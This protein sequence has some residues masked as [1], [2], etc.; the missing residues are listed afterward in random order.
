MRLIRFLLLALMFLGAPALMNQAAKAAPVAAASLA[1]Q[2]AAPDLTEK[3]R[4][5]CYN[6]YSGRFLHW[7][8]CGYRRHYY[9]HRYYWRPHYYHRHYWH[10]RYYW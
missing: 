2:T 7:G 3:A 9:Y 6:R 5:Y 8:A 1:H 10:R 4:L